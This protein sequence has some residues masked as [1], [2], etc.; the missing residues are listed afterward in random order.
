VI[1]DLKAHVSDTVEDMGRRFSD[2]WQRAERGELVN[3]GHLSFD[4]FETLARILTP[5][6]LELLRHLHR[7]PAASINALAKTVGRDYRRVHED[8]EALA[9]A[10][11]VNRE[12]G[13]TGLSMPYDAIEMRISL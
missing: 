6:R 9:D 2:A 8:V 11:L 10:G 5:K 1:A 7:N 4:S 3:E 13:G 12:D